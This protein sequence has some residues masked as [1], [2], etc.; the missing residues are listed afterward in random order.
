MKQ[1]AIILISAMIILFSAMII[2]FSI[3]NFSKNFQL[4][5]QILHQFRTS[6]KS[7]AI[8][9]SNFRLP[10]MYN[11]INVIFNSLKNYKRQNIFKF[12]SF[13]IY[14]RFCQPNWRDVEFIEIDLSWALLNT[15]LSLFVSEKNFSTDFVSLVRRLP[16]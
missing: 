7:R 1:K 16:C 15:K 10:S 9:I 11:I 2:L 14:N 13:Q 8:N 6:A 12:I 4:K 5:W 3:L